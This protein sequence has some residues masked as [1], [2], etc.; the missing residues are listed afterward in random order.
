MKTKCLVQ[1]FAILN[2]NSTHR[3]K[4]TALRKKT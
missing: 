1:L 3:E 2:K 4:N